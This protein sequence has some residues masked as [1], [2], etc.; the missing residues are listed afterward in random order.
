MPW[1]RAHPH[2]AVVAGACDGGVFARALR[3]P[4]W[5]EAGG[6]V[7]ELGRGRLVVDGGH[8]GVPSLGD[9]GFCCLGGGNHGEY[10]GE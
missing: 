8:R 5:A 1:Q 2:A 7:A 4:G 6:A 10:Q 9:I 3:L